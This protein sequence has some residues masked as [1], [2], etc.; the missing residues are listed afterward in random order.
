MRV[1]SLL[2]KPAKGDELVPLGLELWDEYGNCFVG[3]RRMPR[4][5]R[6]VHWRATIAPGRMS[7]LTESTTAWGSGWNALPAAVQSTACSPAA[8]TRLCRQ[9]SHI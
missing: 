3:G 2:E 7:P 5:V 6:A 8:A 1:N 9:E 4:L